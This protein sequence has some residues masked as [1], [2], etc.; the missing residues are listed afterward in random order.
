MKRLY[1]VIAVLKN[2]KR[3]TAIP[4][5]IT[6]IVKRSFRAIK[7]YILEYCNYDPGKVRVGNINSYVQYAVLET[8]SRFSGSAALLCS[9]FDNGVEA[10]IADFY[11]PDIVFADV[12]GKRR[13]IDKQVKKGCIV[14]FDTCE[15]VGR[16]IFSSYSGY[17][18]AD[19][20]YNIST[21][22][23]F[24]S[25]TTAENYLR[26]PYGISQLLG[27]NRELRSRE[28]IRQLLEEFQSVARAGFERSLF[29]S[30]ICSHDKGNTRR[31]IYHEVSKIE[32]ID[33][34]GRLYH[35]DKTL[36]TDYED[37]KID[38]LRQYKFNICPENTIAEGYCTE[39][40]FDALH[41][42]CI[43][44]YAGGD[45][46]DP[47]PGILNPEKVIFFD[48][49]NITTDVIDNIQEL[50]TN[51]SA[52]DNWRDKPIFCDTAVDVIFGMLARYNEMLSEVANDLEKRVKGRINTNASKK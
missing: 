32:K 11:R 46:K 24:E 51:K 5:E 41:A 22:F 31:L 39:K 49:K 13:R 18:L 26:F 8:A 38:Y 21:G 6:R 2:P 28:C 27:M 3:A 15:E 14:V 36:K 52:Y 47:E 20:G 45:N 4:Q 17:H 40:L 19:N 29:C 10:D 7:G 42:G 34:P 44:I 50:H 30:L 25:A 33:C 23:R 43:P 1:Q 48:P 37:N 9:K 35:N 12:Y 16:P